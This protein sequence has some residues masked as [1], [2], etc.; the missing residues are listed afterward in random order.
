MTVTLHELGSPY[1]DAGDRYVVSLIVSDGDHEA[2]S[3]ANAVAH[4]LNLTRDC[5]ADGTDWDVFDRQTPPLHRILQ[6]DA[7]DEI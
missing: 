1:A 5:D 6:H 2:T 3:P 4:R 7:D